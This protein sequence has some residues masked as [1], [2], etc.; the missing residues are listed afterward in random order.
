LTQASGSLGTV[1]GVSRPAP[2]EAKQW[3]KLLAPYREPSL[4]R[5]LIELGLSFPPFIFLWA[6]AWLAITNGEWLGL[7]L[8]VPAAGFLLRL[9]LIQHDCGHGS[10]FRQRL[11]N[12]WVGRVI[13][14]F[15]LT[16]YDYWRRTHAVHHANSGNLD[17]RGMGDVTTLTVDEYLNASAVER[18]AY[19]LYRNPIV[20]FGLGSLYLFVF[21][22]RLPIGLMRSGWGPWLSVFAT[23]LAIGI[24]VAGAIWLVG[25]WTFLAIQGPIVLIAG[26]IGVWLFYV[27][28]QF[29]DTRWEP[30]ANWTFQKAAL[31]GSSHYDLPP[32]LAWFTANIGIH[33]VH[34]LG[35][36]IPYYRLPQ[37][38]RD[39][40]DLNAVGRLGLVDSLRCVSL[41][42]WD[43][44]SRKL[45]S[46]RGA[47]RQ[48]PR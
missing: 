5:S 1:D 26:T 12:D 42:L 2:D 15:T 6:L 48:G 20:M 47:H 28:H 7:L 11:A 30:D 16:P 43:T 46:F 32:A 18:F 14:V 36:R 40:P 45:I 3:V 24:S 17:H 33:H 39:H 35:S 21:K 27:Q 19:R 22:Y 13:S 4:A 9:F 8:T 31:H 44:K 41:S 34:H 25:L 38:L 10:F 29:E 37:V 23:N